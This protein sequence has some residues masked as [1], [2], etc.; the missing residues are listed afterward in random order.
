MASLQTLRNKGGIIVA[1]VIG[2]ALLAFVLG[3]MLTSGSTLFG[4]SANSV[5]VIDETKISPM[6]YSGQINALTEVQKISTG[7]ETL[8]EEQSQ[9][10]QNQA[11]EQLVRKYATEPALA[12]IGLTVSSE[13]LKELLMGQYVSP[14]VQQLFA[15][16][17]T[18][19]FE[20]Q[21]FAQFLEN[22]DQDPSG[23]MQI[24]LDYL[25]S[26][27]ASQAIIMKYKALIDNSVY[28][29]SNQADF[30]AS[31]E[32]NSYGVRFV[33]QNLSSIADSTVVISSAEAKAFY[34][35]NKAM[36]DRQSSRTF[37]YVVFEALPSQADYAAADKYINELASEFSTS[38]NVQQFVSLNSQSPFDTRYY[39]EGELT[40]SLAGFAFK[41]TTDQIY[42]PVLMGDEY[43]LARISDIRILP[44][45]MNLSHIVLAPSDKAKADSL[46]ATLKTAKAEEWAA[47]A[48]TYSLD[49]QTSPNGG[50]IGAVDPQT[51][52]AQFAEPLYKTPTGSVTVVNVGNAIHILR[53][54]SRIGESRKVQ[55]GVVRYR[56]EPSKDTRNMTFAKANEFEKGATDK[57][58]DATVSQNALAA[59][60]A[61]I[62][63]Q[64]R[65][66]QGVPSSRELARW[67]YN[68]E[69]GDKSSIMEFGD[70]F[71]VASL[72]TITDKGI[73][74]FDDVKSDVMAMAI[75]QKKGEML[76]AKVNGATSVDE[77]ASKLG[78]SVI[79][80]T[81]INFNTFIVPEI[82][83][84]PA[85]A[86][87]VCGIVKGK[88]KP[89]IG[90]QAVYAVQITS[91]NLSPIDP[92]MEK[93]KLAAEGEQSAF[94]SVYQ[95]LI[96]KSEIVDQRYKFY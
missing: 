69:L 81:D 85:F 58:F 51:L 75:A 91:D 84:D 33:A 86:G 67:A 4:N 5:G 3:D 45:T 94:M 49:T 18:G 27:V 37:S 52:G 20:P 89:I 35:K 74:P 30:M 10:I 23:R 42:G 29:T 24:F 90:S 32:G 95:T 71:V 56:V 2:L 83:F 15:N 82:G 46:A 19:Q 41:S 43:T 60:S 22:V 16:P 72:T 11:W 53:V 26:E 9:A 36:F 73:A 78:L 13:E 79:E 31:V 12:K 1:V 28:I 57:G 76:A 66:V 88:I 40:D 7:S 14:M 47:A 87:G 92:K 93:Q 17:Q 70:N 65:Q 63:A 48:A 77:L 55:L 39:K 38:Q 54:N 59:R 21:A 50:L 61:T 6:E 80:G 64:D 96:D 25:Q 68:A 44:D 8:S 62:T 34:D